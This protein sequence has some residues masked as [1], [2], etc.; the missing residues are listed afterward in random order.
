[1]N[2]ADFQKDGGVFDSSSLTIRF[3]SGHRRSSAFIGGLYIV[4]CSAEISQEYYP[5]MN[6]DERR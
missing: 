1:M 5:P 4:L 3:Q 6:A 2:A